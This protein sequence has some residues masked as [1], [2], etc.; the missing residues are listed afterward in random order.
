MT[1]H[2]LATPPPSFW[3]SERSGAVSRRTPNKAAACI[4]Y[5]GA[6]SPVAPRWV[7]FNR[8]RL[9][10]EGQSSKEFR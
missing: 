6:P 3:S 4:P 8:G 2:P 7:A 1:A 9:L 10:S 5:G